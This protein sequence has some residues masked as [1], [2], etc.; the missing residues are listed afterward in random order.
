MKVQITIE[1]EGDEAVRLAEDL[2]NLRNVLRPASSASVDAPKAA[3]AEP[4]EAVEDAPVVTKKLKTVAPAKPK[5][6]EKTTVIRQFLESQSSA[7]AAV[8]PRAILAHLR[9]NYAWAKNGKNLANTVHTTLNNLRERGEVVVHDTATGKSYTFNAKKRA[10]A[11]VSAVESAP[12]D[13]LVAAEEII[14]AS[15]DSESTVE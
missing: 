5:M 7:G 6:G 15:D 10:A 12:V 8:T 4:V 11:A 13:A 14:E 3:P 9:N 2:N 1:L